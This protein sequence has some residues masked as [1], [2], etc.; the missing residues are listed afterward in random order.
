MKRILST[1][2]FFSL[3]LGSICAQAAPEATGIKIYTGDHGV[4]VAIIQLKEGNKFLIQVTGSRSTFDGLVL[5]YELDKSGR[6]YTTTWRGKGY[7]FIS[8]EKGWGGGPGPMSLT[9]PNDAV[10]GQPLSYNETRSRAVKTA[11]LL[12]R[13]EKQ[14]KDG[15]IARFGRFDRPAEQ[16]SHDKAMAEAAK[17]FNQ[18][19]GTKIPAAINWS[20][21]S[22]EQMKSYW[23]SEFCRSPL[24]AMEGLC[25]AEEARKTIQTKVKQVTCQFGTA[26]KLDIDAKGTLTWTTFEG[27]S[28]ADKLAQTYL[29]EMAEP[30]ASSESK[31]VAGGETPPWG[32]GKNLKEKVILE[33]TLLCND[34]KS[35]FVAVAPEEQ[36]GCTLYYGNGKKFARLPHP[37]TMIGCDSFF[38]PRNYNP[39]GNPN[40]R[41]VDMRLFSY[42]EVDRTKRTC[43]VRCG[44]RR[45][46]LKMLDA[47]LAADTL[48]AASFEAP[49]HKRKPH[50]LTRDENGN[51]YYVDRGN[52]PETEKNF[53]LFTGPR[54]NLKLRPMTNIIA[55][56]KGEIFT[57]KNGS[58]RFIAG[59]GGQESSWV[60]GKKV[61]KLTAIPVEQNFSLIYN[62]LGVYSGERLGTQCDDL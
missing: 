31:M 5:P 7:S 24:S 23:I 32:Q 17:S 16:A 4:E 50:V 25:Q 29:E 47:K 14:Y 43:A 27:A 54:G 13:H 41:G 44:T 39:N 34:G 61:T 55:D 3:L 45:T 58:L 60:Q 49:L 57:T 11:D 26:M 30:A 15:T 18:A 2:S 46:E 12:A 59:P 35:A 37:S 9:T 36:T 6:F 48:R 38:D 21:I 33:K 10:H 51:Y 22:E 62:D 8:E 1:A 42:V 52:S 19:C 28:N 40:F 56:S 20:T 53:R